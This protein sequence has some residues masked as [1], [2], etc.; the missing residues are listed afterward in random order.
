MKIWRRALGILRIL[1]CMIN[2]VIEAS[3]RL[4]ILQAHKPQKGGYFRLEAPPHYDFLAGMPGI[5]IH[6]DAHDQSTS[7]SLTRI[8]Y[9]PKQNQSPIPI[10]TNPRKLE[11][12]SIWWSITSIMIYPKKYQLQSFLS[13]SVVWVKPDS[14][15]VLLLPED[16]ATRWWFCRAELVNRA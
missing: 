7:T 2:A 9:I 8:S 11:I 12:P 5:S 6:A 3:G 1:I 14:E 4:L 10:I 15:I 13:S 16:G